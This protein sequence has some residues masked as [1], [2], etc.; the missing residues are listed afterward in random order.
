MAKEFACALTHVRHETFFLEKWIDHYSGI[1][2]REN[3]HVVIDGDDWEPEVDLTG[4]HTEVLLE[5]PRRRIKNDRFM[6]KEMSGRANKLRKRY[7]HV[8]RGD[9]DEYVVIDPASGLDWPQAFEELT[10]QGYIFALGVDMVE[11][12]DETAPIDRTQP[13]LGQRRRGFVAD[14]YT[15]PFV[16]TRWNNWAGGAHRLLNRPTVI[17]NHFFLFHM[18]L[19]D[20]TVAEERLAARGGLQQ[21]RSFVDH[22]TGRLEA[23][24][25]H[26]LSAP[27]DF[28][29]A[30][31]VG[32]GQFPVEPDGSVTKRPRAA[33]DPRA[34]EQGL[35][36]IVPERF[37]GLA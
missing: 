17:S 7:E 28:A 30:C 11:A 13:I 25:D 35:P 1:V 3:L 22:Q 5:A 29:E 33:T 19:A 9:V 24:A 34:T 14:R 8:I 18:A 31:A 37:F 2:G 36:T 15:K 10:E 23:I 6:A 26:G 21:H 4:I 16:I 32:R 12:E 20:K 27:I